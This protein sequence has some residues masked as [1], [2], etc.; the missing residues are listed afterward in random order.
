MILP[1]KT[2]LL[3]AT[4]MLAAPAFAQAD[5]YPA[6]PPAT[7]TVPA[8]PAKPMPP[9]PPMKMGMPTATT[10]TTTTTTT[11]APADPSKPMP[12][13][14][15][16]TPPAAGAPQ[17]QAAPAGGMA[18]MAGM[19]AGMMSPEMMEECMRHHAM[20]KKHPAPRH[21]HHR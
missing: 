19:K 17:G 18:G 7:T 1:F 20:H 14:K 4:L 11:T 6:T 16:G 21:R 5:H 10:T 15:M 9:M 13:M 3:C 8:D 2:G 12:P